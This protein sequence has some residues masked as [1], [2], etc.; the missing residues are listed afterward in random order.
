MS[1]LVTAKLSNVAVP[2]LFKYAVDDL[3]AVLDSP[4]HMNDAQGTIVTSAFALLLGCE[5]NITKLDHRIGSIHFKD[6]LNW[7]NCWKII[8]IELELT[9]VLQILLNMNEIPLRLFKS[10]LN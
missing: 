10:T 4:L 6:E 7:F 5:F 9:R 2:F 1:L 8:D 3:N